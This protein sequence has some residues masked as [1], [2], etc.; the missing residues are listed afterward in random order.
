MT[1]QANDLVEQ[2]CPKT[3]HDA[4]HNNEGCYTKHHGKQAYAGY[5][6]NKSF[7]APG[8]QIAFGD[9]ALVGRKDHEKALE[10]ASFTGK[11]MTLWRNQHSECQIDSATPIR[12]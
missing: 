3:V 10:R 5:K 4:H 2:F 9:H 1:V 6:K 8:K 7:A 12:R 11:Q